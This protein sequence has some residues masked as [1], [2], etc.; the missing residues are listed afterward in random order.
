MSDYGLNCLPGNGAYLD[1]AGTTLYS[2]L[3]V[4]NYSADLTSN[5]FGNPHSASPSSQESTRRI[6]SIRLRALD[7]FHAS[8]DDFDLVFVANATAA[9]KLVGEAF[10]DHPDGFNFAYHKAAHTSLVGLREKAK[11][12]HCF[13]TDSEV[14]SWIATGTSSWD[15]ARSPT[16]A[17]LFAY[18]AQSNM[19]GS[20]LRL[21]WTEDMRRSRD[22]DVRNFYTLLDAAAFVSTTPL[23]LSNADNAPDFVALSFNKMFGFP[24]LGA[25]IVKRCSG[26]I[27]MRK[28]YFGGGTVDM[29]VCLKEAW[30]AKKNALH[31]SLEDGT[32]PVH[33]IIALGAALD[34]HQALFGSVER[35]SCHVNHLARTLH[36]ALRS[37]HHANG[38]PICELYGVDRDHNDLYLDASRQGPLVAFNFKTSTGGWVP[39]TTV[40]QLAAN[41]GIHLRTGGLCNPGGV[42]SALH[43]APHEMQENFSAGQRCG[44]N[45]DIMH[46]KPTGIVRVSFGAMSTMTDVKYFMHEF[47]NKY[48]VEAKSD[49][50]LFKPP[51][52]SLSQTFHIKS[53]NIYPI[54]S[55]GGFKIESG[56]EWPITEEGLEWDREWCVIHQGTKE[57]L[58]QKRYPALATIRTQI[59]D[60]AGVLVVT[61]STEGTGRISVPLSE[62]PAHFS[63]NM[64]L[65]DVRNA[66]VCD[67]V[68]TLRIYRSKRIA[69][70]FTSVVRTPCTLARCRFRDAQDPL[71]SS[72]NSITPAANGSMIA[73][74]VQTLANEAPI[75]I[76]F[77]SSID[78]LNKEIMRRGCNP[79]SADVFRANIVISRDTLGLETQLPYIEDCFSYM[80]IGDR[81]FVRIIGPCM[82]CQ[83]VCINQQ[84][85]Q[86]TRE[87]LHTLAQT[88]KSKHGRIE[89]GSLAVLDSSKGGGLTD[90][91][92]QNP[93]I[94]VGNEVVGYAAD[95]PMP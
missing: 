55:C 89:F 8:P 59:D 4:D 71:R 35:T 42:A 33:N 43:L 91:W 51:S 73:A 21:S 72:P 36:D 41:V 80:Q 30:H 66:I 93:T 67:R 79:V 47:M 54:K 46:G 38:T 92:R 11:S 19:D 25:L 87:P 84:T 82:R 28:K 63:S 2:K 68:M 83:V 9:I 88:R 86:K 13:S 76:I 90:P 85:G 3:L 24:D 81:H 15:T 53:L 32:L 48:F 5:L 77:Q 22:A 27:L 45:R 69:D 75:L 62:D 20:R 29:V 6:D 58:S 44:N 39:N 57:A 17:G 31:G 70:F 95:D 49:P 61:T 7:W 14:E 26:D 50:E 52:I 12:Y 64:D 10:G 18:P 23:D 78:E 16:A 94:K 40:E 34:A 74:T 56:Q 37:A 1:H 60:S 65:K